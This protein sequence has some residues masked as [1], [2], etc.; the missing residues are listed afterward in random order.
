MENLKILIV[1]DEVLI[2]EDLKDLLTELG[3]RQI[4]MAHSKNEAE[5]VL[6]SVKPDVALLDIRMEADLDGLDLAEYINETIKIP[7]IYITA[8]SD[9]E[10][11]KEI[12][13]TK[14][15]GYITKPIKKSDLY[16]T[17]NLVSGNINSSKTEELHIKDGYSTVVV[18]FN[19]LLYVESE[20]NYLTLHTLGKKI[21]S[22]Q[23]MESLLEQL[24]PE[25]FLRIHRSYIVNLSKV[26]K[27]SRKELEINGIK[28]PVSRSMGD[29]L[30]IAMKSAK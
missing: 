23:S 24:K 17:L 12:L 28:I 2:A 19:E 1:D 27:Y 26:V 5:Q 22:R 25:S 11:I 14:P 21:V 10:M 9:V 18:P 20:G 30:E 15:T 7:F 4:Y 8:H 13:K 6:N 29:A 16:A 3:C